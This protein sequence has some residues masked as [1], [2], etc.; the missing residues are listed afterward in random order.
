MTDKKPKILFILPTNTFGGAERVTYNIIKGLESFESFLLTQ[1]SMIKHFSDLNIN[2]HRF[3]DYNCYSPDIFPKNILSYIKAIRD[4]AYSVKPSLIFSVMHY[5][6][7]FVNFS[8]D[9]YFGLKKIPSITNIHG[10]YSSHFE[11]INRAPSFKEKILIHYLL[12]RS[13]NIVVPSFGIRDDLIRHFGINKEKFK[14]IYNGFD[15]KGIREMAKEE[16]PIKKD[17]KWIVTASRLGPPKDFDTL[18]EAFVI[19]KKKI[20][21]KL[22]IIGDGPLREYLEKRISE[23]N[24]NRYVYLL[25]FQK[26]PFKYIVR[27]DLF[28][29]S[30]LSEGLPSSIIEAMALGIP[31]VSTNCPSGP[32]EIIEDKKNGLLVPVKDPQALASACL[33][34][35]TDYELMSYISNE[36]LKRAEFFSLKKTISEY[37]EYLLNLIKLEG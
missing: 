23:L 9:I 19:I 26:N 21:T 33:A 29:L 16:I 17:S 34:I 3:E 27:A 31:V 4:V 12:R 28:V 1:E 22:L 11:S 20:D 32:T 5:A 36:A 10:T 18:L 6:S 14:V 2:I 13:K 24:L 25:G 35:L 37:N 7:L 30:S 8:K 15:I